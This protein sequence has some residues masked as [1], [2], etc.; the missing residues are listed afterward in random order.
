MPSGIMKSALRN[1]AVSVELETGTEIRNHHEGTKST[2][3]KDKVDTT[4]R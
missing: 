3:R 1:F 2:K 4:G